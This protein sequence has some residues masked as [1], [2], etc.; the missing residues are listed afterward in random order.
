M[1]CGL[2]RV[3]PSTEP[4]SK[5]S[6]EIERVIGQGGFGK[7]NAVVK[8]RGYD[9]GTW[10]AMK[11]LSKNVI[12]QRNH[13]S[14]VMKER[15]LLA[16]LHCP[17]LVNMHYAFQDDRHLYIVM[18]V[19]LGGD[20]HYQLTSSPTKSFSE[21][22]A[23][24]YAA[25]LVVCLAYMH[26]VGVIHRDIKPENL[27]LDSRGQLKVTDLGISQ[28]LVDGVCNSTSGTRPYMA[29]EVF[30]SGHRHTS[31]AD[32]YSMGITVFQFLVGKR[33]YSPTPPNMK[34][35]VRM[36]TFVPPDRYKD[37]RQIRRILI[38]AQERKAPST[39]FAYSR[40]LNRFSPEAMDFV[41]CCLICNPKYRL[42]AFGVSEL[43]SHPWFAGVDWEAM[44]KQEV[45]GAG[46]RA[47]GRPCAQ[48]RPAPAA[49]RPASQRPP[50]RA[51]SLSHTRPPNPHVRS[52]CAALRRCQRRCC[53]TCAT[54]TATS[55]RRT[56]TP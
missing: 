39:D 26:G 51:R 21:D 15:N 30:M 19:C 48:Q 37:L 35:I 7:V 14:M 44:R 5:K 50:P 13:V 41:S 31:V 53:Q 42:G 54:P 33:P 32:I 8:C 22:V 45:R 9:K 18:D 20:L 46:G 49:P 25:S 34:A 29:P 1:G 16:R 47:G 11:S 17:Q 10:Y 23:R 27:L 24:F 28:E 52:R 40:H 36:A 38:N 2:S 55:P 43:M 56:C 6:F 4:V 12:L 3:S